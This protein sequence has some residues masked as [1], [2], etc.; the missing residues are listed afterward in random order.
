[1]ERHYVTYRIELYKL[2]Y[3]SAGTKHNIPNSHFT[4]FHLPQYLGPFQRIL[5]YFLPAH[6]PLCPSSPACQAKWTRNLVRDYRSTFS[7]LVQGAWGGYRGGEK[8]GYRKIFRKT[9]I[10]SKFRVD[11]RGAFE[12][13]RR[14][15]LWL[16]DICQ[17]NIVYS[18]GDFGVR[19]SRFV[20][21]SV[22]K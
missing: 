2:S 3:W 10:S 12:L 11:R 15:S 18:G 14:P 1:M 13:S 4:T 19:S 6:T 5:P 16:V 17:G 22:G 8:S 20:G 21:Y 7:T 9:R